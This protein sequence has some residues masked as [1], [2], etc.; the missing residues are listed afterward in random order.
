M[1]G[2]A[3]ICSALFVVMALNP[4]RVLAEGHGQVSVYLDPHY[5]GRDNGPALDK[6]YK[7]KDVT[8]D[9][10]KAVQRELSNNNITSFLSREDDTYIPRGDRWFFA[11]KKG[12]DLYLSIRLVLQ[13]K[14]CVQLYH[15]GYQPGVS[16]QGRTREAHNGALYA[17]RETAT[18]DSIRLSEVLLKSLKNNE[19]LHCCSV[20]KKADVIFE[21]ADFPAVIIE[22]G[23]AR[24]ER[25]HSYMREP[26]NR[27][28]LAKSIAA[29]I[30]EFI[31]VRQQ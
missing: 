28:T 20:H 15:A 23:I 10:A 12:A 1:R 13:D 27:E 30:K 3:L 16:S 19:L 6:K 7:G 24:A 2:F 25:Q 29:A 4:E 18:K 11:K 31:E 5:G 17:P 9:I 14:D 26:A 8:L 22:F 21:T